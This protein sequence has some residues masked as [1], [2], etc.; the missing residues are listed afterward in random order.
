MKRYIIFILFSLISNFVFCER[1]M[2][3][4]WLGGNNN[5]KVL[6]FSGQEDKDIIKKLKKAKKIDILECEKSVTIETGYLLEYDNK[7]I[8]ITNKY[9]IYDKKRKLFLRCNLL[10]E[11]RDYLINFLI[12]NSEGK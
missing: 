10:D 8:E 11:C 4:Y 6:I 9:W 12:N 1:K 2:N 3:L 7:Q 5:T